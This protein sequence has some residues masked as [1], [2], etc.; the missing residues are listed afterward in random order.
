MPYVIFFVLP[1]SLELG[2][3]FYLFHTFI[4]L[5]VSY[6]EVQSQLFDLEK[7]GI[8]RVDLHKNK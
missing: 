4:L 6:F 7:V 5:L 8:N 1:K 3:Y 2:A